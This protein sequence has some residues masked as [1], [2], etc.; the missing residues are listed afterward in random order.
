MD[1]KVFVGIIIFLM[2]PAFPL[3]IKAIATVYVDP[4]TT[5]TSVGDTFSVNITISNVIDLA[6]WEFKLYY[7]S[8]NLNGTNIVEGP[9]LGGST[10]FDI[11]NFTDNHNS[12]HGLA[13]VTCALLGPG[14]GVNGNGTLAVVTFNATHVG[15]SDLS[16]VDTWLSDSE[17]IPHIALSG[18]VYVLPHDVAI[19]D[20]T[21]YKT[22]VGQGFLLPMNVT[23]ENQGNF[24][25]TF[26]VTTY[27]NDTI[28]ETKT[29]T[30]E[31][32]TSTTLIFTWNTTGF[33]KGNYTI[34]VNTTQVPFET[35]TD[36]NILIDGMVLV[37]V[38]CDVTGST[39]G[40]PDGVCN[41]RDIG[42]MCIHFGTTP[43]SPNW[44]PNCDVTGPT[45]R[46]PDGLVNMRDIG[47]AC[48]NFGNRGL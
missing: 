6:G 9:F 18:I 22:I 12:T 16:L 46:T 35:D 29:V 25:E 44:D 31:N 32:T 27:A 38:P 24:T 5:V 20:L 43:S 4:P 37:G 33:A 19:T 15:T 13:W 34:S 21:L 36:D 39:P 11:I 40:M 48:S 47:E 45:P 3:S 23:I 41:M 2:I 17:P 26:D 28:I 14:P 1:K 30:L 8:S 7:L 10:Y 42:Y